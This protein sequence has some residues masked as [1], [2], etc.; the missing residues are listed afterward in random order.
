MFFDIDIQ[1]LILAVIVGTLAAIVYSL[2]VL[3]LMERRIASIE[4]HIERLIEKIMREE[5]VIEKE[6]HGL[7]KKR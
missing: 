7:K 3:V 1:R 2:R 5:I 4:G 6:V